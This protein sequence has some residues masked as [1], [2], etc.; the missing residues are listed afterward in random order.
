MSNPCVETT[1][2]IEI[3]RAYQSLSGMMEK[4]DE[5]RNTAVRQ[6]AE[7]PA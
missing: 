3:S 4:Q 6:L 1:R 7:I 2:L 5:L